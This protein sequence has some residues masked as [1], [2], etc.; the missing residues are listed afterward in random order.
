MRSP[1]RAWLTAAAKAL[2]RARRPAP[3]HP[4][5]DVPAPPPAELI[6]FLRRIGVALCRAGA[7]TT[8]IHDEMAGLATAYGVP[9]V[10]FFVVP[11][12]VFVRI[13]A[14][15]DATVDFAPAEL[16]TL[17]LDQIGWLY[18]LIAEARTHRMPP[19]DGV[20][21][22]AEIL[23]A[24]PRF[25]GWVRACGH[26][27]LTVGL[28]LVLNADPTAL[29]GYLVLGTV[30]A[31]LR[32]LAERLPAL[33]PVL[34]VVA[35]I[36]VTAV[37]YRLGDL[38][39][40]TYPTQLLIPSLVT[41]LP[42][43]ALTLG[44]AEIV[45][46]S[47][48]AGSSR[49]V[50]GMYSLLLLAFGIL[51]GARLAG[52]PGVTI[53]GTGSLGWWAPW[54]GV[55]VFGIGQYLNS[56]GPTRSLPWLLGTLYLVW[57]AQFLAGQVDVLFGAFVGGLA[58]VPIAYLA[59]RHHGPPAQ[60]MFLSTFWLLVPGALGLAGVSELF[61]ANSG[62]GPADVLDAL[63]SVVAISL[64]TLAGFGFVQSTRNAA[65]RLADPTWSSDA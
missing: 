45:T 26:T 37:V 17:R 25:P 23:A 62:N 48:I 61:G 22:L 40:D 13:G 34:P 11:T 18:D 3:A 12:G 58:V 8:R 47:I 20:A 15:V 52:F 10:Y 49:L 38:L 43:A 27:M 63:L 30:V 1:R 55:L 16:D 5:R 51:A 33:A 65:R 59:E 21:R 4:A 56:S 54:V 9:N 28:G 31:V 53:T 6:D 2:A 50:A 14:G 44:A 7:L 36:L 29:P 24:P 42:G 32:L 64:G 19:A 46:G 35:S 39:V 41:F 57:T 60:V